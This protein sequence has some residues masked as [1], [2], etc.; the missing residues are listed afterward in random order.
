[1]KSNPFLTDTFKETWVKHFNSQKKVYHFPEFNYVNFVESKKGIS[2][3]Y[4][5][6]GKTHTKGIYYTVNKQNTTPNNNNVLL[7]YDVPKYYNIDVQNSLKVISSR[8]Y[9]GFLI[10]LSEH[11]DLNSYLLSKFKKSSRYKLKKY[12]KRL[13]SCF[14]ISTKSYFGEI[15]KN[16]YDYIFDCF[17]KLLEKRFE[18]KQTVNNNLD[19]K[20]WNFYFEVAYQLILEKKACLFVIYNNEKPITI[21]LNYVSDSIIYDAITVFD[22]DYSKFH[23]GSVNI[24]NLIEWGI[25]K[26]YKTLDFSKGYFDYKTRWADLEYD[27]EYHI[28]YNPKSLI[29]TCVAKTLK[30]K[31]DLKQFLREHK[32]NDKLHEITYKLKNRQEKKEVNYEL[33][34]LENNSSKEYNSLVNI[35]NTQNQIL[36]PAIYDFLYLTLE[37]INAISVYNTKNEP[38]KYL[39]KGQNKSAEIKINI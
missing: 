38:N 23:L 7:I 16:E 6:V 33:I 17:R 26:G 3:I 8:Q 24:M 1:M 39:I 12:K 4:S 35:N 37:N 2:T 34:L 15:E 14:N 13:E 27:F 28:Y 31:L 21:T 25:T 20:E 9:P 11:K 36:I 32:V 19:T 29:A 22:I 5:N 18:D 10:H 30:Y